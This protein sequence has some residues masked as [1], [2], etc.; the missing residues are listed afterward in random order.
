MTGT[1][2]FSSL[3]PIDS[4]PFGLTFGEWSAR[5]WQWLLSIPKSN[6]PAFDSVGSNANINQDYKPVFF[7]CQTYEGLN[8]IPNRTVTIPAGYNLIFIPIINWISILHH[9]GETDEDLLAIAKERMDVVS[10]LKFSINQLTTEDGL[11]NFRVVSPFFEVVLP[12]DNIIG[13]PSGVR[14]A[15]SDGYWIFVEPKV[16]EELVL[17]T[18]G[19]CSAGVTRIG[20]IYK[21]NNI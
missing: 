1:S 16:R 12:E 18:F 6:N 11:E 10:N 14:R 9:D 21:I 15:I 2:L 8:I 7:L 5:W 13:L 4:K 20:V 17:T 19:S 3:L